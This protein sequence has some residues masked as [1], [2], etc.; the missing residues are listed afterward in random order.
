MFSFRQIFPNKFHSIGK[1]FD[2]TASKLTFSGVF[3]NYCQ[4]CRYF[5]TAFIYSGK[6]FISYS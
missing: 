3:S 5:V 4:R 6:Q 2:F 1:L